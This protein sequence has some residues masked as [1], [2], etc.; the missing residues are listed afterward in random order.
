MWLHLLARVATAICSAVSHPYWN[1]LSYFSTLQ[2]SDILNWICFSYPFLW[3]LKRKLNWTIATM[4]IHRLYL[5]VLYEWSLQFL[6]IK[7]IPQHAFIASLPQKNPSLSFFLKTQKSISSMSRTYPKKV[8]A[9]LIN[10]CYFPSEVL[11]LLYRF[12]L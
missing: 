4:V 7:W 10:V 8:W 3:C 9:I 12:I 5:L 1:S 2:T 6:R 11:V